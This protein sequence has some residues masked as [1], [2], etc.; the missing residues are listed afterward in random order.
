MELSPLAIVTH[1]YENHVDFRKLP[2][3]VLKLFFFL[4]FCFFKFILLL[5]LCILW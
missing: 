5:K 2:V 1:V 4:L 3:F